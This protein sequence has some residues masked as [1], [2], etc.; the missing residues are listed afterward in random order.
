M[1]LLV[2]GL[3]LA[4]LAFFPQMWVRHVMKKYH[5]NEAIFELRKQYMPMAARFSKIGVAR[6]L[7]TPSIF[8]GIVNHALTDAL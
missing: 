1:I 8:D 3:L 6:I 5:R 4:V 7:S 2:L